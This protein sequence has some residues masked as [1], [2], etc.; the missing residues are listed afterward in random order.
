MNIHRYFV[1]L[2]LLLLV[3]APIGMLVER[4]DAQRAAAPPEIARLYI[5]SSNWLAAGAAL[6]FTIEGTPRGHA[7][8][9]ISGLRRN[10]P[11]EEVSSG[12]YRG[13]YTIKRND[14]IT[15]SDTVRA[16]LSAGGLT[17]GE[18]FTF[19]AEL[20]AAAA[21][22]ARAAA[23]QI[24]RFTV[25]PVA[26]IAPG[27]ELRF[28]MKGTPGAAASFTIEGVVKNVPMREVARGEYQGA[29]TIRRLDRF[30]AAV[31]IY[32]TLEDGGKAVGARLEQA[33]V[34]DA[35][36][37]LIGNVSPRDG[38]TI[39]ASNLTSISA[40]FEDSGGSGIDPKSVRV[41]LAGRDITPGSRITPQFFSYRATLQSGRYPVEITARDLAGRA[42]RHAWSFTVAGPAATLP[43]Q[44]LSHANNATISGGTTE[45]RGRTAPNAQVDV[46]VQSLSSIAG[47]F[48]VTQQI[49]DQSLR[50]DGNGDFAFSFSPQ[51]S[52]PGARYEITMNA[53]KAD[54]KAEMN[55]VL[56]QQQ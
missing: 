53:T 11:L 19:P 52:M 21:N 34:A 29:Y 13:G 37:P 43:L 15:A 2:L 38:E 50:A 46:K 41:T 39:A 31:S 22:A 54:L 25:T 28:A 16:T 44:V 17:T 47:L 26:S 30:P 32:G 45:V 6:T 18:T 48:G 20:G 7:G 40:T 35:R 5:E 55:M 27:T 42:V 56:L 33:L 4:A 1:S 3:F 8:V 9:R 10:I 23:P 51:F 36:S 49:V 12:V 24:E 14:R